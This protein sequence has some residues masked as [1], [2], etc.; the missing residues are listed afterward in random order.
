MLAVHWTPVAN[1]KKILRC[2]ITKSKKGLY[3]FPLTGNNK[4]DRWWV[5]FFNI[6]RGKKK[7]NGI[8]FKISKKD[9]P[10]YFGHW[11]G[12]TTRD[13]FDKPILTMKELKAEYRDNILF[14]VGEYFLYQRGEL[15]T[16]AD[17]ARDF[18]DI[19]KREIKENERV[20]RLLH[21]LNIK[22]FALE[23]IQIVLS[24]SVSADRIV[25]VISDGT[26]TG[27]QRRRKKL[28]RLR[29][30]SLSKNNGRL[31]DYY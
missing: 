19:A 7:Y 31:N 2:G 10:A 28:E 9:L 5:K 26:D 21:D 24:G 20:K 30:R 13:T 18:V 14:R 4:V 17:F 12:A 22:T 16:A 11:I 15:S 29:K 1:T 6:C 27:R 8:I 3:C 23:D 25:K